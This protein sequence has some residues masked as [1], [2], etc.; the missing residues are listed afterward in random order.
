MRKIEGDLTPYQT[1]KQNL[2]ISK[3]LWIEKKTDNEKLVCLFLAKKDLHIF[4][5][6]LLLLF[7]FPQLLC[8]INR[9]LN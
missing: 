2:I 3:H 9:H 4:L 6:H 8:K 7:F 5:A 1:M